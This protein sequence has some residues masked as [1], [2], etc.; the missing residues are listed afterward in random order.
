MIVQGIS[1]P[2]WDKS[3]EY[4]LSPVTIQTILP[5]QCN[6]NKHTVEIFLVRA[7]QCN[8]LWPQ[9]HWTGLDNYHFLVD[10]TTTPLI[11]WLPIYL[12]IHD[13]MDKI[14]NDT[15]VLCVHIVDSFYLKYMLVFAVAHAPAYCAKQNLTWRG[16]QINMLHVSIVLSTVVIVS[17]STC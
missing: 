10:D 11:P 3:C 6:N 13:I 9:L 5:S 4:P 15:F 12:Y 2:P 17:T 14:E 16:K 8:H 1:K 7:W